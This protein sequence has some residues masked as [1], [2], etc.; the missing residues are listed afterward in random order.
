M[1]RT[2]IAMLAAGALAAPAQASADAG[3]PSFEGDCSLSG[4]ATFGSPLRSAPGD[5]T[6]LFSS[7][8]PSTC[9]GTLRYAGEVVA[10]RTWAVRATADNV[11]TGTFSCAGS[12]LRGGTGILTFMGENGDPVLTPDGSRMDLYF[13]LDTYAVGNQVVLAVT[14]GSD[15]DHP[16]GSRASGRAEFA[17]DPATVEACN[18]D[19]VQSLDFTATVATGPARRR[20]GIF[21]NVLVGQRVV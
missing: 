19:G 3:Y 14:G 13:Q 16:D 11:G 10:T 8:E 17:A 7:R 21:D 5:N 2:V 4:T 20:N 9:T 6:Y 15:D 12:A 18:G 1:R